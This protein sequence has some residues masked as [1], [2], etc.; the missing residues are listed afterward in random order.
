MKKSIAILLF[1]LPVSLTFANCDP[2][3][4]RWECDLPLK[5]KPSASAHSLVYCGNSYGYMSKAQYDILSRYHRRSI[6]MVLKINGEYVDS[7][8]IPAER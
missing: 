5:P 4:F 3:R 8:C 1:I 7:P 6:N 2:S